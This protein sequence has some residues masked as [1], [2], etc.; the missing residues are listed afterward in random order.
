MLLR[1]LLIV[2]GASIV[3]IAILAAIKGIS[4]YRMVQGFSQPK[5]PISVAAVEARA[6]SWQEQLAAIGTLKAY[7]GVE[8]TAEVGGT[9][10]SVQFESG[11][12]VEAGQPIIE[13]DSA[14]E[15]ASLATA[16][17]TLGLARVEFE[18]GRNLVARQAISKSE[19]DRLSAELQ[20]ANASVAQLRAT[21][22]RKRILAP[23][24]GTIGI[25][26]VDVGAYLSPGTAIATLQDLSTLYVDFFLPEQNAPLLAVGQPVEL[27]VAAFPD[28]RFPGK[29]SAINPKVETTTRNLQVRAEL[30]NPEGKL[31]PGMFANLQ[32]L[33]PDPQERVVVPE[34]AVSFTLYGN[35]IYVVVDQPEDAE[36]KAAVQEGE[37]R[38]A[39]QRRFVQTGERRDGLVVVLDG[40]QPGEKV[41]TA[42]QLKLDDGTPVRIEPDPIEQARRQR[43]QTAH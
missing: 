32:V 19:F 6:L 43:E 36:N 10:K 38:L 24:P 39:V 34:T 11:Q 33:L 40:I 30:A 4:I 15:Q 29:I 28:E 20:K 27:S 14:V 37:P 41:V 18:R 23:F 3:V 7:R 22:D 25:R 13:L 16:E 26:Q 17:A 21:L 35:S 5:P 12:Q 2:I 1:R 8:L 9:V 31:L 42:G